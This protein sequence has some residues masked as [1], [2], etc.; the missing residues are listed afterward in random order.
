MLIVLEQASQGMKYKNK[1]SVEELALLSV[2]HPWMRSD[3]KKS[4]KNSR[5]APFISVD[6]LNIYFGDI[7]KR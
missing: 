5:H 2:L 1:F 7:Y 3:I 4:H 6:N